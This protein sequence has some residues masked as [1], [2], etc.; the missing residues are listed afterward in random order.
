MKY[1]LIP[2]LLV[3]ATLGA[4]AQTSP[5]DVI[6]RMNEAEATYDDIALKIW[7]YAEV[8]YQETKSSSLLQQ[9][10]QKEGFEVKN[11][12]ADEPT[13]FVASYGS[14]HPIIA[15]LAEFDALP[16]L[17][18]EAWSPTYK[19]VAGAKAGHGCGHNLIGTGA[20]AAASSVKA[21]MSATGQKGTLRVY[22]CPAEEG[23]SGKVYMVRDG[24]F[25]DVDAVLHWH[26]S[27]FNSASPASNLANKSAKFRFHGSVA[28][29]VAAQPRNAIKSLEA[30]DVMV[31]L[32][33]DQMP[34]D[35]VIQYAIEHG[36]SAPNVPTMFS[37]S[38]YYARNHSR[39]LAQEAFLILQKAAEGAAIGTGTKMEFE[40]IHGN[41]E[42]LPNDTLARVM[43]ANMVKVGGYKYTPEEKEFAEKLGHTLPGARGGAVELAEM[44]QP[45]QTNPPITQA[46]TDVGDV[47]WNVP[48]AG[49][50]AA[51]VAPGVPLHSWQ[52]TA[53]TGTTIGLKGMM[54]A[55]KTLALTA[56]DLFQQPET[57]EKA[58]SEMVQRRG[59]DFVYL[60]LVG[61]RKPPLTYRN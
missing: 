16:E 58:K 11:I 44:I 4:Q 29:A 60:P 59:S 12:F 34:P 55:A 49:C 17:E 43:Y 45:Y 52:A 36:G 48:T 18:Q 9:Q 22:G 32:M 27:D 10:L 20:A 15:I 47:S 37:E 13:S 5:K 30:M 26:P 40:I 8:G 56:M 14:G 38:F 35:C 53:C 42:I 41:F 39:L 57:L 46:S 6:S 23:G 21:W 50:M 2:S 31:A 3:F 25:K 54:V 19:P 33:R 28:G 61:N 51:V 1:L 24:L 7:S